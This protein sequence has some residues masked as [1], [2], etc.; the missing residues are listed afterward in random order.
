[1]TAFESKRYR[2]GCSID[3]GGT[4]L[5]VYARE[6]GSEEDPWTSVEDYLQAGSALGYGSRWQI[7]YDA[8]EFLM[9]GTESESQHMAYKDSKGVP[10][11]SELTPCMMW[12][13]EPSSTVPCP[14]SFGS[15]CSE[16]SLDNRL[17]TFGLIPCQ[18]IPI[19][20]ECNPDDWAKC[21]KAC[22]RK[23]GQVVGCFVGIENGKEKLYCT[24]SYECTEAQWSACQ[25]D[26]RRKG[27]IA[28]GCQILE[29]NGKKER[30]CSCL[31]D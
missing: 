27:G 26:C 5:R 19:G 17:L 30:S 9:A 3:C 24:C 14:P 11:T 13:T 21:K 2:Y 15:M 7:R 16:D 22:K 28:I 12:E 1:M 4:P 10:I 25:R 31:P 18:T 20:R 29:H 8:G 23:G 6:L